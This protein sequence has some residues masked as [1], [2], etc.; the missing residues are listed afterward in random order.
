[1]TVT[2]SE[3]TAY[4]V[5]GARAQAH[6]NLDNIDLDLRKAR[7][8]VRA[9]AYLAHAW[10]LSILALGATTIL[11][12]LLFFT[13]LAVGMPPEFGILLLVLPGFGYFGT[14]AVVL[15]YPRSRAKQRARDIDMKLPYA[16]N[17]ITAMA[18]A[19]V[20]PSEIFKS[21]A[22]QQVYGEAAREAA[23]IY[24]D[25]EVHGKD[26]VTA[27]RR[28]IDR[29]P[30]EKF[31]DLLQGAITTI[32]SGGDLTNYFRTKARRLQVENRAHQ[33]EFIETMG[34]MSE[35]YVTAAVAGPLFLLVMLVIFVLMNVAERAMLDIVIYLLIPAINLGFLYAIRSRIPEV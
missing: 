1:M 23:W 30:S 12:I 15:G 19:G 3:R 2:P 25:L 10:F 26:V 7:M 5:F 16:A 29:S 4:R 28:A 9:D 31:R 33:Q 8:D 35:A 21:L 20:I 6:P 11:A 24:K 27:M 14:Q 32:T 22:S 17:Y 18:S 34:L 13:F